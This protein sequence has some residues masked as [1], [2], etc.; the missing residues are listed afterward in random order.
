MVSAE[1]LVSGSIQDVSKPLVTLSPL[2]LSE[3]VSEEA[4]RVSDPP[5][6]VT[7][8]AEAEEGEAP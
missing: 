1:E 5:E 2:A 7:L 4:F 6:S 3:T 8:V